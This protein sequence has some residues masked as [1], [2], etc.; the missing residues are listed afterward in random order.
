MC[1]SICLTTP[2]TA[3]CRDVLFVFVIAEKNSK[4]PR[5]TGTE[6]MKEEF[7]STNFFGIV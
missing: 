7:H 4:R 5:R 6:G 2:K 3:E 1:G